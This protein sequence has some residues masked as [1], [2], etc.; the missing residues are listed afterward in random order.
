MTTITDRTA[1][2]RHEALAIANKVRSDRSLALRQL[3]AWERS[4]EDVLA[5]PAVQTMEIWEFL[6]S[7]PLHTALRQP[8]RT[9]RYGEPTKWA[10]RVMLAL[11]AR[12][13]RKIDHLS[14]RQLAVLLDYADQYAPPSAWIR[15]DRKPAG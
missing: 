14:P 3:R 13:W 9:R 15:E 7:V 8:V 4:L 6:K 5:D 2:Q 10:Q 11:G 1:R 12:P